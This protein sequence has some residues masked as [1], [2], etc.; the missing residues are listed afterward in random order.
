MSGG[1]LCLWDI[2]Q[3]PG[4]FEALLTGRFTGNP[5]WVCIFP[6]SGRTLIRLLCLI[7]NQTGDQKI[8]T[9][10]FPDGSVSLFFNE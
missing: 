5:T 1:F 8:E 7:P 2:G 10:L 9:E 4:N 3:D 6:L